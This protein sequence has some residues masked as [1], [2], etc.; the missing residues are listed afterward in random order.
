MEILEFINFV[1]SA[2][3]SFLVGSCNIFQNEKYSF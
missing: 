2:I 1:D 3:D